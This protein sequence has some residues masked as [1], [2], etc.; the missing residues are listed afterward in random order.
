MCIWLQV[1]AY[2]LLYF[3]I[4][5]MS[6]VHIFE[7]CSVETMPIQRIL[8]LGQRAQISF[9]VA[10]ANVTY[11][12]PLLLLEKYCFYLNH[13]HCFSTLW[14]WT[15]KITLVSCNYLFRD[16]FH[17]ATI[18]SLVVGRGS[19]TGAIMVRVKGERS[20]GRENIIGKAKKYM[21][22]Y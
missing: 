10:F 13:W 22:R 15:R 16:L 14:I 7:I 19:S 5:K 6:H 3:W 17:V 18:L 8:H 4:L 1:V 21:C 20:F 2:V 11:I 12:L 9:F